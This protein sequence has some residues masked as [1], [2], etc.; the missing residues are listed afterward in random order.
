[1]GRRVSYFVVVYF[2]ATLAVNISAAA[3]L[4]TWTS[5]GGKFT[6]EATYVKLETNDKGDVVV[7]IRLSDGKEIPVQLDKLSEADQEYV[8]RQRLA[9]ARSSSESESIDE[10]F[11]ETADPPAGKSSP[12]KK[13]LKRQSANIPKKAAATRKVPAAPPAR[14]AEPARPLGP[15]DLLLSQGLVQR[16]SLWIATE[17]EELSSLLEKVRQQ[18]AEVQQAKAA[19][20]TRQRSKAKKLLRELAKRE[21]EYGDYEAVYRYSTRYSTQRK[22][23]KEKLDTFREEVEEKTKDVKAANRNLERDQQNLDQAIR[24]VDE[25]LAQIGEKYNETARQEAVLAAIEKVGGSLGPDPEYSAT[26]AESIAL[27]D[28]HIPL[29]S[30]RYRRAAA[31]NLGR[32]PTAENLPD[33]LESS[34]AFLRALDLRVFENR[35]HVESESQVIED[36]ELAESL[37]RERAKLARESASSKSVELAKSKKDVSTK[38]TALTSRISRSESYR[39]VSKRELEEMRQEKFRLLGVQR[40]LISQGASLDRAR[41]E[42]GIASSS[43]SRVI[44]RARAKARLI[45]QRYTELQDSPRVSSALQKLDGEVGPSNRYLKSLR[46]VESLEEKS[47]SAK[48]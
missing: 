40:S 24:M 32:S 36:V 2:A 19:V 42:K 23:L 45:D 38:L 22:T 7:V 12:L 44:S 11:D 9:S 14:P 1:M 47:R 17:E 26:V 6:V 16:G 15:V 46:R 5:A 39:N 25:Q 3:E 8:D 18:Q 35:W 21:R 48:D 29:A 28:K 34:E 13:S 27:I 33:P 43:F 31:M 37:S 20:S 10:S 30:R 41:Q 4:R